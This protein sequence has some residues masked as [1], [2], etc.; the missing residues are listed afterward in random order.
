MSETNAAVI[1]AYQK[2]N[3]WKDLVKRQKRLASEGKIALLELTPVHKNVGGGLS[4]LGKIKDKYKNVVADTANIEDR[5]GIGPLGAIFRFDD[6]EQLRWIYMILNCPIMQ[7]RLIPKG[8]EFKKK[9]HQFFVEDQDEVSEKY[10]ANME[11]D[12]EYK[13]RI[14][15]GFTEEL[16]NLL[17]LVG[18]VDKTKALNNKK[19]DLCRVWDAGRKDGANS[20]AEVSRLKLKAMM[21]NKDID[22]FEIVYAALDQGDR[23]AQKGFYKAQNG[24]YKFNDEII[25]NSIEQVVNY[26]KQNDDVL[27]AFKKSKT[28]TG[29]VELPE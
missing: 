20:P 22:V 13:N 3:E 4:V 23:A 10:A 5:I 9:Q 11:E 16:I 7:V 2:T 27:T 15:K 24:V 21:D 8:Q 26:F 14:F 19:A 18:G 12:I 25:G 17:C 1:P 6:P 29:K 28:P